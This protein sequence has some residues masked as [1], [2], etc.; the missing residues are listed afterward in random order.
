VKWET[1]TNCIQN[2]ILSMGG[3]G[4][5]TSIYFEESLHVGR[6]SE[7]CICIEKKT[8]CNQSI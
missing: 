8:Q 1:I 3:G 2:E 5:G 6:S 4:D 7:F